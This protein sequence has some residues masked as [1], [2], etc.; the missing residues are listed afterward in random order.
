MQGAI[1]ITNKLIKQPKA[2]EWCTLPYPGHKHGCPN[3]GQRSSCPPQ[4]CTIDEWLKGTGKLW[5]VYVTFDLEHHVITMKHKHPEKSDRWCRSVLYWQGTVN[6]QLR[7]LA[8]MIAMNLVEDSAC[9]KI[10]YCPEAMGVDVISTAQKVGLAVTR[11]YPLMIVHKIALI[12]ET[13]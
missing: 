1:D 9:Y 8:P 6:K 4:V 2:R 13:K 3:Y 10:T 5:L 7:E 11:K 12:A